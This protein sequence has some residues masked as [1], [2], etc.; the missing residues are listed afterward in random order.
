MAHPLLVVKVGGSLFDR[1]DLGPRLQCWL[2]DQRP[3]R[4]LLVP[5]GGRA[6]DLVRE[7]D[8]LHDLGEERSHWLALQAMTLNAHFL[9][10]LVP[11]APLVADPRALSAVAGVAILDGH[12]F[13]QADEGQS[14]S[15]PHTWSVTSD[16]VAARAAVVAD[17]A[18]LVL[19]KSVSIPPAVS[20]SQAIDRGWVDALFVEV[21]ERARKPLTVRAVNFRT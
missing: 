1:A 14:G 5:G 16:S 8:R 9:A 19:L 21:L 3:H 15:L 12:A 17:A 18:A 11:G 13:A 10:A 4:V 7:L 20:W 2:E 6:A